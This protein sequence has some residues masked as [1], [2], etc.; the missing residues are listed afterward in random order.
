M[1]KDRIKIAIA[2]GYYARATDPEAKTLSAAIKAYGLV[3]YANDI[4]CQVAFRKGFREA[5]KAF[6]V[7][8]EEGH[9]FR[10]LVG[11]IARLDQEIHRQR[12]DILEYLKRQEALMHPR[13]YGGGAPI[14][15]ENEGKRAYA[16]V[17][18]WPVAAE[19]MRG[20]IDYISGRDYGGGGGG[21]SGD[22]RGS[23]AG[24]SHIEA[25]WHKG[26]GSGGGGGAAPF[27]AVKAK[28]GAAPADT[29]SIGGGGGGGGAPLEAVKAKMGA[30]PANTISIGVGVG[31]GGG[32][33]G[34][35]HMIAIDHD[36]VGGCVI[37]EIGGGGRAGRWCMRK[38]GGDLYC[39]M[40]KPVSFPDRPS[41]VVACAYLETST[42]LKYEP[43]YDPTI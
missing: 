40:G 39:Q 9:E 16:K 37:T 42:G 8:G 34:Q 2:L 14:H 22:L 17:G 20:P 38:V 4:D 3:E 29:I 33:A 25:P 10:E 7:E 41:C 31:G 18:G 1:H 43:S 28:M 30:A 35:D 26:D 21:G 27:E 12:R 36:G 32:G 5:E 23:G 6:A 19:I 13:V 11:W 24:V 15:P